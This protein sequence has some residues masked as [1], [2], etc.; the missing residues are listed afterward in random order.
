M[1]FIESRL[2]EFALQLFQLIKQRL[3]ASAAACFAFNFGEGGLEAFVVFLG[4]LVEFVVQFIA[5]AFEVGKEFIGEIPERVAVF[6]EQVFI[7]HLYLD[8]VPEVFQFVP[9]GGIEARQVS[10]ALFDFLQF[11]QISGVQFRGQH[12]EVPLCLCALN[13]I[14]PFRFDPFGQDTFG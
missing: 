13:N 4:E 10:N 3:Q 8:F 6:A 9:Y 7:P 5:Q 14:L 12:D 2:A 1:F 11:G